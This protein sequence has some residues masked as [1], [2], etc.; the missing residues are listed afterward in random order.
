[1]R[2]KI[3]GMG[4]PQ[5]VNDLPGGGG[6]ITIAPNWYLG[7]HQRT[8]SHVFQSA[9][10]KDY[11]FSFEPVD[12]NLESKYPSIDEETFER[13]RNLSKNPSKNSILE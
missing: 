4:I 2:G 6:K 12:S 1:M 7:Y 11:H 13:Y 3:A 10:T 8:R 5:F 9:I